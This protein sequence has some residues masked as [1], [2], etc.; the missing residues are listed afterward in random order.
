MCFTLWNVIKYYD[1]VHWC[2]VYLNVGKIIELSVKASLACFTIS[3][4]NNMFLYFSFVVLSPELRR[5]QMKTVSCVRR[6]KSWRTLTGRVWR[7][8]NKTWQQDITMK[9]ENLE[10]KRSTGMWTIAVSD[11]VNVRERCGRTVI[12]TAVGCKAWRFWCHVLNCLPSL[13]CAWETFQH[14]FLSSSTAQRNV[15][16]NTKQKNPTVQLFQ[17]PLFSEILPGS[18]N[19]R[20]D[21][22]R[23]YN[24]EMQESLLVPYVLL[25]ALAIIV[26]PST[27]LTPQN[28]L[29]LEGK[30]TFLLLSF[31]R[32]GWLSGGFFKGH[33]AE[34]WQ[35]M[36][37]S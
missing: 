3:W 23:N 35:K 29:H 30:I 25:D 15:I 16:S 36:L 14:S 1:E 2:N 20:H 8:S 37:N 31:W 10:V 28:F 33:M 9:S 13:W 21:T 22:S 11:G 34:T 26:H 19:L 6:S 18:L 12:V 27:Y 5:A 4:I 17:L 32:D 7:S 24:A